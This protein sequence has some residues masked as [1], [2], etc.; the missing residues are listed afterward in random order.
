MKD[1]P[2]SSSDKINGAAVEITAAD[3]NE[4]K[5]N[6]NGGGANCESEA[7]DRA[8]VGASAGLPETG[9]NHVLSEIE[10][11]SEC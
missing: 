1:T 7:A 2:M 9:P 8:V 6:S 10:N 11:S 5:E 4:E 3:N